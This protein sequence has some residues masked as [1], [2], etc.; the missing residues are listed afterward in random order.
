MCPASICCVFELL[1]TALQVPLQRKKKEKCSVSHAV[2]PAVTKTIGVIVHLKT[3]LKKIN[4]YFYKAHFIHVV[5]IFSILLPTAQKYRQFILKAVFLKYTWRRR[6]K[7][8]AGG[9]RCQDTL[10][11][12]QYRFLFLTLQ[13]LNGTWMIILHCKFN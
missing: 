13:C 11:C 3:I 8:L 10:V 7:R 2:A 5:S 12:P 1:F 4:N 9:A 6:E